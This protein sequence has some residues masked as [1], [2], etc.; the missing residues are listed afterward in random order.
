MSKIALLASTL[1][2]TSSATAGA[3]ILYQTSTIGSSARISDFGQ[4]SQTGFRSF[5]DFTLLTNGS[6]ETVRWSG[7]W[8]DLSAPIP[9]AAPSPDVLSWDIAFFADNGGVPGAPLVTH[10]IAAGAVTSTFLGIG[11][12]SVGNIYNVAY[13]DY[14]VTLPAAF[15]ATAQTKYWFSVLS[16]SDIYEP[17][18]AWSGGTGKDDFSFQQQLGPGMSVTSA[19]VR[20]RDRAFTLEGT[21]PVPEPA[22]ILLLATGAAALLHRRKRRA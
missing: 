7:F 2:L 11:Q 5:D 18:F 8:I 4:T 6:V 22:S 16:R 20:A 21:V 14:A 12:F 13:Y 9:T 1:L 19:G 3:D 17:A 10:S 15:T